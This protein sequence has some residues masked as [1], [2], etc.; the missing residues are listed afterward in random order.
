MLYRDR[1]KE[2][3]RLLSVQKGDRDPDLDRRDDEQ[4]RSEVPECHR[5]QSGSCDRQEYGATQRTPSIVGNIEKGGREYGRS[6]Q[7]SV[8]KAVP[9]G[10]F[11]DRGTDEPAHENSCGRADR[12]DDH[13][14]REVVR[15]WWDRLLGQGR[16]GYSRGGMS[17]TAPRSLPPLRRRDI[18]LDT[19]QEEDPED[20]TAMDDAGR[21]Q[22]RVTGIS[23]TKRPPND[24]SHALWERV[25]I[26][27]TG[28]PTWYTA[29]SSVHGTR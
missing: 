20:C 15:S 5:S 3:I 29:V 16:D 27:L 12:R 26:T 23:S 19:R 11:V 13:G 8:D 17:R 21:C 14:I 4:D 6:S 10:I 9:L 24:D 1:L 7:G 28:W 18:G 25:A 22:R 2:P